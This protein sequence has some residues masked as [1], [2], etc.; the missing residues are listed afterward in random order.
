MHYYQPHLKSLSQK[1]RNSMTESE[2]RLWSYIRGKQLLNVQFYRQKPIGNY[3]VDF[4][5]PKASLVIEI[6]GSQHLNKIDMQKDIQRD[7]YLQAQGICILRFNNLQVLKQTND[8]LQ[9]I[10]NCLRRRI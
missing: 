8:V 6:D 1:L 3:I 10:Y 7:T 5:A 4:Y 2:K 9:V